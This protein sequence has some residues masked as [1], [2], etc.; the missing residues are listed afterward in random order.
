LIY[1]EFPLVVSSKC[2]VI[3][4]LGDYP[5]VEPAFKRIAKEADALR[6]FAVDRMPDFLGIAVM[7][8]KQLLIYR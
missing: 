7:L 8:K 3:R 4:A 5:F 1:T 6:I 2:G